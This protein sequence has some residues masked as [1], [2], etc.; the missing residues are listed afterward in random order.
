MVAAIGVS[1]LAVGCTDKPVLYKQ[2]EYQGKLDSQ[3]WSNAQFKGERVE[4]EKALK[5]RSQGQDEYS[6][7]AAGAK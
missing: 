7:V 3:P 1:L 2:G 5:A 4:W 6:R